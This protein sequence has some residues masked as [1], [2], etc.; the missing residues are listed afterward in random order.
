MAAAKKVSFV[1]AMRGCV[2]EPVEGVECGFG[3]V[4]HREIDLPGR[5]S[6]RKRGWAISEPRTGLSVVSVNATK[7]AALEEL[8]K[9][10]AGY[11]ARE[12]I[13][14]AAVIERL[15]QGSL[16]SGGKS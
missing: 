5:A 4:L 11:E 16:A 2:A 13:P 15:V 7:K 10:A 14:F 1:P 3:L 12:K 9:I 8:G 6:W